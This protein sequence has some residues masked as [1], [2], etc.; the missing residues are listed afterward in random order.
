MHRVTNAS[1]ADDI[2]AITLPDGNV[3]H[4]PAGMTPLAIAA[5]ISPS[6]AK[7]TVA[8]KIDGELADASTDLKSDCTL[9][10]ISRD[11][12]DALALIRHDCAHILAQAVKQLYPDTKVTIGPVIEN[13]FYYDFYRKE[14]FSEDD[15]AAIEKRMHELVAQKIPIQREEQ[16]RESAIIFY[17][18]RDEHFK[19]ELIE[20]IPPE[21]VIR[22]YRQG[23]FIDLCRGPH[24]RTTADTGG[25]FKLLHVSG[26]YWRGDSSREQLQRIYGTAWRN[27]AELREY[28]HRIEEAKRRDHRLLGQQM[29]L[30]HLQEEAAGMV[31]WHEGGWFI[32]RQLEAYMRRRLEHAAY[33]EVST[34]QL[35]DRALWERSGHWD[36]FR[37]NM[38]I[39][40]NEDGVREYASEPDARIFALKPMNCPCHVQIYKQG[41][42]SYRDLPIRMAE[43]GSCHRFEPSGALH[44]LMRVRHFVQDDAHIFCTE[45]QVTDE[46][47]AFVALLRDVYRDLGFDDFSVNFA[48]RPPVRAGDDATWDRAERALRDACEIAGVTYHYNAGEGAF[49]GPKLEF[50]LADALGRQ[51]QCGTWQ[52]DFVLPE[53]LD[54]YYTDSDGARRRPV[55]CHRAILGSFE[56]F[57]GILLEH[58]AGHLPLWL[59]PV[60]VVVATI[61][62][63]GIDYA[64]QVLQQLSAHSVRAR[65]DLRNEKITYKIREHSDGKIPIIFVVGK[66][67]AEAGTVS[68][69]R[70]GSRDTETLSLNAAI[71]QVLDGSA[72][73]F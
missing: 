25:A 3:R 43:F 62:D 41:V 1:S 34:P 63:A 22:F 42:K 59:S 24:M 73:P 32:Y 45:A 49:Y 11:D 12:P 16:E 2:I 35:V 61:T 52:V 18:Q 14:P 44:G 67:E 29:K 71:E 65:G 6:L 47:I 72:A 27:D 7:R 4:A 60:Q 36:K 30:F 31:F 17:K 10:L 5:E 28:L 51:W 40:E 54:S 53:K 15:L 56:R 23:D 64:N 33:Q 69:R 38:Y 48:D 70:L 21:E 68:V 57:I 55:M 66:K 50:V 26:A 37:E 58:Y 39:A 19:V 20:A 9:Q 46:T 8:C 13:G